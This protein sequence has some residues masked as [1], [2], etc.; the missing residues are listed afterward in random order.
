M[1]IVKMHLRTVLAGAVAAIVVSAHPGHDVQAELAEQRAMLNLM[2]RTD[3]S[4]CAEKIKARG[5]EA[6]AIA[7]R[8][9]L[10]L[11]LLEK[12]G[13]LDSKLVL[14]SH[15]PEKRSQLTMYMK[16]AIL[17]PF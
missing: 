14:I 16:P 8:T 7:R 4:H 13:K 3:L 10:L 15:H 5:L 6:R 9:E 2:T 17:A 12:V 1:T 11:E